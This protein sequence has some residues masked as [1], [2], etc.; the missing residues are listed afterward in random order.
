MYRFRSVMVSMLRCAF[1]GSAALL[2]V[3]ISGC[4][5]MIPTPSIECVHRQGDC[6]DLSI[7]E[8]QVVPIGYRT[9]RLIEPYKYNADAALLADLGYIEWEVVRPIHGRLEISGRENGRDPYWFGR[10]AGVTEP[11]IVPLDGQTVR[12]SASIGSSAPGDP[13]GVA[14][15]QKHLAQESLP[16]GNYIIIV[17]YSGALNW[18]RKHVFVRVE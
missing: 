3:A 6:F 17:D 13:R 1:G 16:P 11:I 7:N 14:L 12:F 15:L 8:T 9:R 4:G 18:D 2:S 10:D 5:F